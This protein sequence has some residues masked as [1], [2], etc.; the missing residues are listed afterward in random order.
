MAVSLLVPIAVTAK[1]VKADTPVP[2]LGGKPFNRDSKLEAGVHVHWALPDALTRA[3][4]LSG[5]PGNQVVFPGVPDLWM[6]TRFNQGPATNARDPKR[7]WRAWVVDSRTQT[8]TPFS[9]WKLPTGRDPRML[10]T[11]AG[12]LPSAA[13]VK[14][15]GWGL[16]DQSAGNFDLALAA[17]Y[18]AARARFGLFDDLSDLTVKTGNVSYTVVGWYSISDNDPLYMSPQKEKQIDD[19]KFSYP[20][21]NRLYEILTPVASNVKPIASP[22]WTPSKITVTDAP[23]P[24]PEMVQ[25]TRRMATRGGTMDTR[26]KQVQGMQTA[27]G[28]VA[29]GAVQ[30]IVAG[31]YGPATPSNMVCHG[32]VMQVALAPPAA[33]AA[34]LDVHLHPSLKRAL[35]E[36]AAM[37]GQQKD[38]DAA[39]MLLQDLDHKK[40][41]VA[42]ILDLPGAAHA[43][44]FQGAAGKSRYYARIQIATP[45][46]FKELPQITLAEQPA[47]ITA[48]GHWP[49]MP[50]MMMRSLSSDHSSIAMA[51]R[52]AAMTPIATKPTGPSADDLKAWRD[53]VRK[54]FA[55][56]STAAAAA[57]NTMDPR[58]VLVQD[59]RSKAQP[60]SLAPSINGS[61][62]DGA[63]WWIDINDDSAL[64]Q[65]LKDGAG[66]N[67]SM[68]DAGNLFEVPSARWY[69]PWSPHVVVYGAGRSFRF[70]FDGRLDANGYLHC[71]VTGGTMYSLAVSST[72]AVLGADLLSN[73]AT[74][75]S[76]IGVPAE[77][78][79][80]LGEALLMDAESSGSMA[81]LAGTAGHPASA[82]LFRSAI[83]TLWL[84]RDPSL[85]NKDAAAKVQ[86]KGPVASAIAITPWED[87]FE[88][89]FLDA[90]YSHPHSTL[91]K[92]WLLNEDQVEFVA[93]SAAATNPPAGQVEVF[94]ERTRLTP[95]IA[96]TLKSRLVTRTTT[97]FQ[98]D[99][100]ITQ[101]P[102]KNLSALTFD[103][104]DAV[105]APLVGFDD[106]LF[107]RGYRQRSGALRVTW[108]TYS[109]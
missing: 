10:H 38:V 1:V 33:A 6:V 87:P 98:G 106:T 72:P 83:L 71:R 50:E 105:S 17:Y 67:I 26:M 81:A 73:S 5:D 34:S 99:K 68:P 53:D 84:N 97:S 69:R 107:S 79:P 20:H 40:D 23:A 43:L 52:G 8:V 49:E 7:G 25:N 11:V 41:T 28:A 108:S 70:G 35:A 89:L 54:A 109:A 42:G 94:D 64:D 77:T 90:N 47:G 95:N 61:A 93:A 91:E 85:A 3:T 45:L 76:A 96:Q 86:T 18:P 36:V 4:V 80:I 22:A 30:S 31:V 58:Q 60:R 14:Y 74:I 62:S 46:V 9:S 59:F 48:A 66:A 92:D 15:P 13:G 75:G 39:E 32:S 88:P 27:Q 100:Q 104:L 103:Q 51:N 19:W 44:T 82:D 55:T 2:A 78:R 65:I 63:G 102:P 29:A 12:M 37:K 24:A 56:A 16:W 57:G 101:A 21:T